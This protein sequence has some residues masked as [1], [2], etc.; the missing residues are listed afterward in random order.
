MYELPVGRGKAVNLENPVA[1]AVIGGWS[2]GVIAEFRTGAPYGIT[3]Q[4]NR[5]SAFSHGQRPNCPGDRILFGGRSKAEQLV[6]WFDT[7]QF[8]A[9]GVGI[10]GNSPRNL[11]C[12]PEF[13]VVDVSIQKRFQI[14]ERTRLEF[15][16][17]F[18]NHPNHANFNIPERRRGNSGF[19]R[20]RSTIGTGRQAQLGLRL[21]L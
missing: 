11:C 10:F 21:E 14:T 6:R 12:G 13:A 16:A 2:L 15:R 9:P 20:V 1:N 18:F 4:T 3:E 17:D 19:G 7:S 5:S 8:E